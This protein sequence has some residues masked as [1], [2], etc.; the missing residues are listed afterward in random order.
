MRKERKEKMRKKKHG[1]VVRERVRKK[2][3]FPGVST[4]EA[5]W[6]EN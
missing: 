2:R 4:V 3:G 6:L 5:Q 1:R